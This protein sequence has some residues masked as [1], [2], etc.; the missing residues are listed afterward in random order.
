MSHRNRKSIIF[1]VSIDIVH[2]LDCLY[3]ILFYIFVASNP[4]W[5][6]ICDGDCCNLQNL[7]ILFV[8]CYI[9]RLQYIFKGYNYFIY[10]V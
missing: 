8:I 1:L 5:N 10:K 4:I 6:H 3:P 7:E 2:P 9:V